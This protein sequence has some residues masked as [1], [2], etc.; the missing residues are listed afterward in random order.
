MQTIQEAA[1]AIKGRRVSPVDL[2]EQCFA[3]I[4]RWEPHVRYSYDSEGDLTQATD[5]LGHSFH[6]AYQTHLLTRETNRNGLSF[7]F[8][9]DGF[10]QDAYCVRTWGDGGIYDHLITYDKAGRVTV[11]KDSLGFNT[12]Y[13]MNPVGAVIKVIDP[14]WSSAYI[15]RNHGYLIY[16]TLFALDSKLQPQPQMAESLV[17]R[18]DGLVATIKLRDGLKWHDGA[19]VTADDCVASLKRWAARDSMAQKL[20]DFVTEYKVVDERTFQIVLKEP[21]GALLETLNRLLSTLFS[22]ETAK[23]SRTF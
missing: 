17:V 9:Y 20:N 6:Y 12:T 13:F 14:I 18:D 11:V 1:E 5:A 21:Y 8:A 15:V 19:P 7:Y 4:D 2:V 22:T 16:D 10:G 23:S 3:A